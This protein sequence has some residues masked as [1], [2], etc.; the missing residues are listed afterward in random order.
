MRSQARDGGPEARAGRPAFLA[1]H[2]ASEPAGHQVVKTGEGVGQFIAL[3]VCEAESR[4]DPGDQGQR[5]RAGLKRGVELVAVDEP[6]R[7]GGGERG[8]G[9]EGGDGCGRGRCALLADGG[10]VEGK[11]LKESGRAGSGGRG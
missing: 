4:T 6:G 9:G 8:A 10:R 3:K 7:E 2:A 1:G 11:V 5:V